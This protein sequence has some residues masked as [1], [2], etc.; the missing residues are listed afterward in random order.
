M[1][2]ID[3]H[4]ISKQFGDLRALDGVTFSI[5]SGAVGLVGVNG[6][7]KSTLM[8]VLAGGMSPS[9]GDF[10]LAGVTSRGNASGLR[11]RVALMPQALTPPAGMTLSDFMSYMAW[12]RGVPRTQRQTAIRDALEAVQLSERS[13]TRMTAL[14]GGMLRRALFA[15][16][17]VADPGVLLL[18]EPTAGLDPEQ[19]ASLRQLIAEEARRRTVIISSHLMED[20]AVIAPRIIMLEA[21]RICFDGTTDALSALGRELVVRDSPLSPLEAAFVHMRSAAA[22]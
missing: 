17:V 5:E 13:K 6:A 4:E 12:A 1:T 7:G 11:R 18:D 19:R 15:Q 20:V 21:G 2:R 8:N 14:S 22:T 16:A 9:A 3:V 10:E